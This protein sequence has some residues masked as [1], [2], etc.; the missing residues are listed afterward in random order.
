MEN[1]KIILLALVFGASCLVGSNAE[2]R[3]F[4]HKPKHDDG[5]LNFLVIGDWGRKG[6][7]N[8]TLVAHQVLFYIPYFVIKLIF[9]ISIFSWE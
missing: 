1:P 4:K 5:S 7:Y 2:L 3:C 9:F 8:Q 6:F